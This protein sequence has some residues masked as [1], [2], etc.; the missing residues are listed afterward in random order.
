[1]TDFIELSDENF[2]D[3]INTCKLGLVDYY[4]AW[5]GACRMAAPMF[6]RVAEELKLD[7]YKVDAEKHPQSRDN[8]E[9]TNLPTLALVKDGKIVA[10]LCTTREEALRT[11]LAEHGVGK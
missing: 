2:K 3:T 6:R 8:V 1:M 7:L 5:C 9:I 10:S 4:A 11:F